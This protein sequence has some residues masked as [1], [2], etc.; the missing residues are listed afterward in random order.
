MKYLG[1]VLLLVGASAAAF[2]QPAVPE[3]GAGSAVSAIALLSG[4]LLVLRGRRK[5]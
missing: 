3:I 1:M 4:A 5:K 2:A